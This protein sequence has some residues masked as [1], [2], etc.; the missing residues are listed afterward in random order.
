MKKELKYSFLISMI[1]VLTC[2]P[3]ITQVNALGNTALVQGNKLIYTVNA[4]RSQEWQINGTWE[5]ASAPGPYVGWIFLNESRYKTMTG[6]ITLE[7]LGVRYSVVDLRLTYDLKDKTSWTTCK[8]NDTAGTPD[9]YGNIVNLTIYPDIPQI[10]ENTTETILNY[11]DSFELE[12]DIRTRRILDMY[13]YNATE[14]LSLDFYN[15]ITVDTVYSTYWIY[16]DSAIGDKYDFSHAGLNHEL[17]GDMQNY[18]GLGDSGVQDSLEYEIE[19]GG[20]YVAPSG[21]VGGFQSTW[22][23]NY[24]DIGD[25]D[26]G[27]PKQHPYTIDL[28]SYV[29]EFI[30][31]ADSGILLQYHR[32]FKIEPF[33][34]IEEGD[35]GNEDLPIYEGDDMYN[36][37]YNIYLSWGSVANIGLDII[38][39]TILII[40]II[41]GVIVII[42]LY[43]KKRNKP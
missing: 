34:L 14:T 26:I 21:G 42:Y 19:N 16:P 18:Y 1:L 3:L 2:T 29:N 38:T 41:A 11:S 40:A 35:P 28:D 20:V 6:T 25:P 30:F 24:E 12:V 8:I 37:D 23:A 17:R 32:V 4:N 27:T 43:M 39:L 33:D 7:I 10:V 15:F 36:L 13:K 31:D 5:N 22:I 9:Y